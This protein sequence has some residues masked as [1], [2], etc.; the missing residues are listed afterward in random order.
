MN[1]LDANLY[2]RGLGVSLHPNR[3][4]HPQCAVKAR[5]FASLYISIDSSGGRMLRFDV[6]IV[7]AGQGGAAAAIQLRQHGF[8][9][10][11][12]LIG[13]ENEPPYERPPLS[14]EYML[15]EKSFDRL[16]LR[17]REFWAAKAL[18]LVLGVEV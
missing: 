16:H 3:P 18:E 9:G 13:R 6:V 8:T 11:V 12:A 10:S 1:T 14:K 5:T 4:A 2:V 7:G 15:G 17:P